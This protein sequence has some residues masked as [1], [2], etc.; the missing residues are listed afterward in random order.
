MQ[1]SQLWGTKTIPAHFNSLLMEMCECQYSYEV[2]SQILKLIYN[3][4]ISQSTIGRLLSHLKKKGIQPISN[5]TIIMNA[6]EFGQKVGMDPQLIEVLVK[7]RCIIRDSGGVP[8]LLVPKKLYE[9]LESRAEKTMG[10][11]MEPLEIDLHLIDLE[12]PTEEFKGLIAEGRSIL[13]KY[14]EALGRIRALEADNEGLRQSLKLYR[15]QEA[16]MR[17]LKIEMQRIQ[18]LGD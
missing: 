2:C 13:G 10:T 15:E 17:K 18:G 7:S 11:E 4:R 9:E 12:P 8:N 3:T 14:D 5:E 16:E 6:V 1:N